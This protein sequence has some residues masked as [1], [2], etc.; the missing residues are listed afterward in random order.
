[1]LVAWEGIQGVFTL[2]PRIGDITADHLKR[3]RPRIEAAD[4]GVQD[5]DG[6]WTTLTSGLTFT[7]CPLALRC[8]QFQACPN[9][10]CCE[11]DAIDHD[12]SIGNPL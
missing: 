5:Q 11:T 4:E 12:T 6:T 9:Q 2:K 8:R 3:I 10:S 7:D 1:M